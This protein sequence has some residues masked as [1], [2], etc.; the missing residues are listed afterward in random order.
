MVLG[1]ISHLTVFI[2]IEVVATDTNDDSLPLP[3]LL[4]GLV[5]YRTLSGDCNVPHDYIVP[6]KSTHYGM[7]A[8]FEQKLEALGFVWVQNPLRVRCALLIEKD[9]VPIWTTSTRSLVELI[10]TLTVYHSFYGNCITP[11][12]FVVPLQGGFWSAYSRG[13]LLCEA[14]H[15]LELHAYQLSPSQLSQIQSLGILKNIPSWL[16]TLAMFKMYKQLYGNVDIPFN[17]IVPATNSWKKAWQGISLGIIA[18]KIWLYQCLLLPVQQ[19][20]LKAI[21]FTFNTITTWTQILAAAK[22]FMDKY[23]HD[24]IPLSFTVPSNDLKW[25]NEMWGMELG[26]YY[27]SFLLFEKCHQMSPTPEKLYGFAL[28][29]VVESLHKEVLN[30]DEIAALNDVGIVWNVEV[31]EIW[32]DLLNVLTTWRRQFSNFP[33]ND[34]TILHENPIWPKHFWKVPLGQYLLQLQALVDFSR[35]YYRELLIDV[36]FDFAERRDIKISALNAFKAFY[37]H[38]HIPK[39]F[40]VPQ[41]K[42]EEGNLKITPEKQHELDDIGFEWEIIDFE[43]VALGITIYSKLNTQG[44]LMDFIVPRENSWPSQ[45]HGIPLGKWASKQNEYM[46]AMEPANLST[47]QRFLIYQN[48]TNDSCNLPNSRVFNIATVMLAIEQYHAIYKSIKISLLFVVP[49][50][51]SLS[52]WSPSAESLPLG[53]LMAWFQLN[54][55][56]LLKI[57]KKCL[58][59]KGFRFVHGGE[60]I[61][62]ELSEVDEEPEET[63]TE[64]ITSGADSKSQKPQMDDQSKELVAKI[65]SQQIILEAESN[66]KSIADS[67]ENQSTIT[68]GENN[69]V[70]TLKRHRNSEKVMDKLNVI[71]LITDDDPPLKK[72]RKVDPDLF[73]VGTMVFQALHGHCSIPSQFFIPEQDKMWPETLW[74]YPLGEIAESVYTNRVTIPHRVTKQLQSM[75]FYIPRVPSQDI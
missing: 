75:G 23:D 16:N 24:S 46:Q 32:S 27:S 1:E 6:R 17:F 10:E 35:P 13:L 61:P 55:K 56:K 47:L 68:N 4:K 15:L 38:L 73:A 59:K 74:R 65:T 53:F 49:P 30:D 69:S 11:K 40:V 9:G 3:K 29:K 8:E 21:Y 63:I 2:P 26:R 12:T 18:W 39:S 44:I 41:R 60:E 58:I 48:P 34:Y 28:G 66:D 5:F 71:D 42:K 36:G 72:L 67:R 31:H 45:L 70:D 19:E 57:V 52:Q 22:L 62:D 51:S 37:G 25:P 7:G 33:I 54:F 14:I 64:I 50:Q 20:E 43:L